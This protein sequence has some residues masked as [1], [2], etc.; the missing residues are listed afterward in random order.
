MASQ[1]GSAST[2]GPAVRPG[3]YLVVTNWRRH[4]HYSDRR[5]KWI[6]AYV[7]GDDD[8]RRGL[9]D[10]VLTALPL[11]TRLFLE[12]FL[13]LAARM[14]NFVP[15]DA[16]RIAGWITMRRQDVARAILELVDEGYLDV[17]ADVKV[18]GNGDLQLPLGAAAGA[19]EKP[20]D[21]PS[22]HRPDPRADDDLT[23]DL[24]PGRPPTRPPAEGGADFARLAVEE[25][26]GAIPASDALEPTRAGARAAEQ[27]RDLE[28]VTS[29]AASTRDAAARALPDDSV[30]N[31]LLGRIVALA[32]RGD[33]K[34]AAI[35]RAE[36]RGMPE[37]V[38]AQALE[39]L[40]GRRPRPA[41]PGGYVVRA[42]RSIA[43]EAGI[44]RPDRAT[45][46]R[47]PDLD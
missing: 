19:G 26:F 14:D 37:H 28:G 38:L 16:V 25:A 33:V 22:R 2:R 23:P 43:E 24:T 29:N 9:D 13:K 7:S 6:K 42:I 11:S 44:R 21:G 46:D 39:S 27:D 40:V 5:A 17:V 35:V 34:S 10:D 3:S 8:G 41:N 36:A 15:F 32:C 1:N 4:L 20:G 18:T 47:E 45:I 12:L 31:P 30:E